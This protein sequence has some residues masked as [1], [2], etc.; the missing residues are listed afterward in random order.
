MTS[1][2]P[3]V[4][5]PADLDAWHRTG[6]RIAAAY[7]RDVA[8]DLGACSPERL[9]QYLDRY[10]SEW[11]EGSG[12][13]RHLPLCDALASCIEQER[14]EYRAERAAARQWLTEE[15]RSLMMLEL[16][17]WGPREISF[18]LDRAG[19]Q[20]GSPRV[21]IRGRSDETR[22]AIDD[23]ENTSLM[24]HTH[25]ASDDLAPSPA[26]LNA[27]SALLVSRPA[28][29]FGIISQDATRLYLCREP[30]PLVDGAPES[31]YLATWERDA[32]LDANNAKL[33]EH[34]ASR[35]WWRRVLAWLRTLGTR[36][37]ETT[38]RTS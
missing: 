35:V 11:F 25:G 6:E 20:F 32:L 13:L 34:H 15:A 10:L 22:C 16:T 17:R 31:Q 4:T 29:G 12:S 33:R 19:D 18:V 38:K 21:M 37:A 30:R 14:P 3:S 9:A 27:M 5:A 1:P 28:L 7:A 23:L 2:L 24:V 36:R 26:D 8:H